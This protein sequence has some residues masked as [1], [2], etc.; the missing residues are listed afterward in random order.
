VAILVLGGAGYIGSHAARALQRSGYEVVLYDNLSTGFRR[1]A[2]GFELVEGDIAD[3]A[4]LRPVLAR[5]DAVM[6][7][8]AHAYVGESVENPRKYF[9]NNVVG[10]LS[11]L[12]SVLDAGIRRF[13]FS[14]TCA[15]YG[16]PE[17]I[18]ITEQTPREPVNPYGA[19]KLFFENALEAYSRAYG[20]RSVSLRYFNAAGADDSAEIGELHDPETHLIPRALAA[21]NENGPELQIYGSDYPTSDGTCV[22]DYIHVSDLAD[23]HVR[24]LQHLETQQLE[25]SADEKGADSL[26]INLGTGRGHSVLEVIRAAEN[27]TGRPVRR[28]TVPRRPG[29]PPILV[30]DPA[31]AQTVLGW[32]AKRN[33]ADIVSRAWIWMQKNSKGEKAQLSML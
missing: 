12:N 18:P 5:V 23:A 7:F 11:L 29:D 20:L 30:A 32:T 16:I 17:Q 19:S 8:A 2:Q 33:L 1:M 31:K 22:R 13:V 15:V 26:A 28:K 14:S 25:K 9:Q 3:E 6:H 4:K 27:A 10:A 21:S 24:A